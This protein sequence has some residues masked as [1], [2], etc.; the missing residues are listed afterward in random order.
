MKNHKW[1]ADQEFWSSMGLQLGIFVSDGGC[2][3][4]IVAD[5]Y[6]ISLRCVSGNNNIFV[7]SYVDHNL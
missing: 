4:S 7:D 1:V 3:T 5:R 6:S 2:R